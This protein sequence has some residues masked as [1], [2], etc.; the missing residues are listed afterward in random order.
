M[1]VAMTEHGQTYAYPPVV[2]IQI[3]D[4]KLDDY[5]RAADELNAWKADAVCLQHEFGIFGGESGVHVL[6]LLSSP[7]CIPFM[8]SRRRCKDACSP[9]SPV[10]PRRSS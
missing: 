7:R 1:I 2:R 9:T 10:C 8:P 6:T 3:Q 4:E 5:R